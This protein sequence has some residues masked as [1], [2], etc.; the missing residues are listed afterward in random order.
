M[1]PFRILL[2]I[3]SLL[4]PTYLSADQA[5]E[6][7]RLSQIIRELELVRS[8]VDKAFQDIPRD[9]GQRISFKYNVLSD[10]LLGLENAIRYH[11]EYQN[12]QPIEH[13][14]LGTPNQVKSP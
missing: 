12:T 9:A 5:L 8:L 14:S 11:I 3:L 10:Q 1:N 4:S 7:E 6:Q 13:W 2:L